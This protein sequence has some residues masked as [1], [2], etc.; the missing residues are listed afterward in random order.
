M[1]SKH[2]RRT[3]FKSNRAIISS[4]K[5]SCMQTEIETETEI[6]DSRASETRARVKVIFTRA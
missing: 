2:S 5:L 3:L 6:R 4:A 1:E